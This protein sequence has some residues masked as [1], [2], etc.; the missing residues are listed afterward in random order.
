MTESWQVEKTQELSAAATQKAS[1]VEAQAIEV[2]KEAQNAAQASEQQLQALDK[3]KAVAKD[4][5]TACGK[6]HGSYR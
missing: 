3:A 1:S 4:T 2:T 5:D 6:A